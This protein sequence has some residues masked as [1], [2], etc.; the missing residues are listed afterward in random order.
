MLSAASKLRLATV[1]AGAAFVG[2]PTVAA[3]M[4][5]T[6]AGPPPASSMSASAARQHT[7]PRVAEHT[8]PARQ[9]AQDLR[10]PD[11][12]DAASGYKPVLPRKATLAAGAADGFDAGSAAVGAAGAALVLVV[13][14]GSG[15]VRRRV[16]G[17]PVGA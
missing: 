6:E 8:D 17:R 5:A 13:V 12:R 14:A 16:S 4:P 15:L 7:E 1:A 2:V 9:A 11:T 3:A 10:M